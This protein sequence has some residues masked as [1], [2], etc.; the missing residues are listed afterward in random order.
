[1]YNI[2]SNLFRAS[3][4]QTWILNTNLAGNYNLATQFEWTFYYLIKTEFLYYNL[5]LVSFNAINHFHPTKKISQFK[6]FCT[7]FK[8]V[9]IMRKPRGWKTEYFKA[10]SLKS[11]KKR[12]EKIPKLFFIWKSKDFS[13]TNFFQV[14]RKA[15]V[16]WADRYKKTFVLKKLRLIAWSLYSQSLPNLTQRKKQL[17]ALMPLF[18]IHPNKYMPL[19]KQNLKLFSRLLRRLLFMEERWYFTMKPTIPDIYR[20]SIHNLKIPTRLFFSSHFAKR[21]TQPLEFHFINIFNKLATKTPFRKIERDWQLKRYKKNR[22]RVFK[23]LIFALSLISQKPT[24]GWVLDLIA[25]AFERNQKK[26]KSYIYFVK[27]VLDVLPK[28]GA[29]FAA[30]RFVFS[31]K[32]QGSRRTRL[33]VIKAGPLPLFTVDTMIVYAKS[34]ALTKYG[35]QGLKA[36]LRY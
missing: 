35:A 7:F 8:K 15:F 21:L 18:R 28:Y 2:N 32:I 31:G 24:I 6:C 12:T 22:P 29:G 13:N 11:D 33:R 19:Q 36:W 16:M 9:E 10:L 20:S 3:E 27:A 34:Y 26:Q 30:Y 4:T 17:N 25:N 14:R 1:M 5:S 23:D